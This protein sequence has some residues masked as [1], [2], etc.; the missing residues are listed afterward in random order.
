[1][2]L[3]LSICLSISPIAADRQEYKKPEDVVAWLYR[4]FAWEAIMIYRPFEVLI[5]QPK[6]VLEQYFSE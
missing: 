4:D 3:I 6:E 1:L 2:A 5:N